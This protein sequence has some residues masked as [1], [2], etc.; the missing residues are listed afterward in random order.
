MSA[1]ISII[2]PVFNSGS[3]LRKSIGSL[4][5]QTFSDIQIIAVNDHSTDDSGALL[6]EISAT[7]SR[8]DV[9][10]LDKNIGMCAARGV[11][12]KRSSSPWIGFL[13]D[14]DRAHPSMYGTL[15]QRALDTDAEIAICGTRLVD[16]NGR[17]IKRWAY[18]S[19]EFEATDNLCVAFCRRRFGGSMVWNKLYRSHI[20]KGSAD[21]QFKWRPNAVED[22]LVNIGCFREA[23]KVAIVNACLHDYLIHDESFVHSADHITSFVRLFRGFAMAIDNFG[24]E[25]DEILHAISG[26]FRLQMSGHPVYDLAELAAHS[27]AN[28]LSE[29]VHLISRKYPI[30]LS[31]LAS[32]G[33]PTKRSGSLKTLIRE[34]THL[35]MVIPR[36]LLRK[37]GWVVYSVSWKWAS[38]LLI[39]GNR[40]TRSG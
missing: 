34:W 5:N 22:T 32:D 9:I 28:D 29:A 27:N 8:L 13:D 39:N 23:K 20:M 25:S 6:D 36:M 16:K 3:R 38:G 26:L 35:T 21:L 2:V 30:G 31:M 10:H 37:I 40:I 15:R 33:N 19:K 17:I 7:D 24:N 4:L 11:G 1:E 18:F 12:I 14:D